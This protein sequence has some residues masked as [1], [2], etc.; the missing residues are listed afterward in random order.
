M[1]LPQQHRVFGTASLFPPPLWGRVREGGKPTEGTPKQRFVLPHTPLSTSPPQ[2]GREP[3]S[4][5]GNASI[6]F[7]PEP[8]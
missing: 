5:R 1:N 2:G 6:Q 4:R 7:K 8:A 3:V